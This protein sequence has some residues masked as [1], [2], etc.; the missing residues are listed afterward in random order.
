MVAGMVPARRD[1]AG[2]HAGWIDL[3]FVD[4][5][6]NDPHN[7]RSARQRLRGMEG[8][9]RQMRSANPA[10]DIVF[11]CF[12]DGSYLPILSAGKTPPVIASHL[13]VARH[14]RLVSLN[15]AKKVAD[16]IGDGEFPWEAFRD[17]HP[18]PFGHSLY[19]ASIDRLFAD[20][21]AKPLPKAAKVKPHKLP[22]PLDAH[23]YCRA[24]LLDIRQAKLGAGWQ[25]IKRWHPA[26]QAATR[27]GFVNVPALVADRPGAELRLA[28]TGT[29]VGLFV[30]A[31]PDVGI[32]EFRIDGSRWRRLDLFT[33]WST[34]LHIPWPYVL[35]ADLASGQHTL[36][37]RTTAEHNPAGKGV[38][39]GA[40]QGRSCPPYGGGCC[41]GAGGIRGATWRI[42][43]GTSLWA[44]SQIM[45]RSRRKYS[46]MIRFRSPTMPRHGISGWAALH[47]GERALAASPMI[48][49]VMHN[50]RW[51]RVS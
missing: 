6:V 48:S 37:L 10:V 41:S 34:W 30:P 35:D 50:A 21:C 17:C 11:L 27:P 43:S 38:A 39:A 12:I 33:A 1:G 24:R 13:K 47:S 5:P 44:I 42:R 14:Y 20:A 23:N 22:R 45:S 40:R 46:W 16:R 51:V 32:L 26:D 29:A 19:A 18:S 36:P 3:L 31:G 49:S 25:R 15:L 7:R 28:F 4:A 2:R 8:I 9:V